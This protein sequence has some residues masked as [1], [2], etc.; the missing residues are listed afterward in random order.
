MSRFKIK[1]RK[2]K[3]FFGF[4]FLFLFFASLA[5]APAARAQTAKDSDFDGLTDQA[6]SE[7]YKTDPLQPDTDADGYLDGAEIILG[8]DPLDKNDPAAFFAGGQ[9]SGVNGEAGKKA[10][11]WPWYLS[12]SFGLA[13][14]LLMFLV[15][16]LGTGIT[17]GFLHRVISPVRAAVLHKYMSIALG[18]LV[19]IHIFSLA[20]DE[21]INFTLADILVPLFSDFK[22]LYLNMGI[23]S[24]YLLLIIV[25]TSLFLINRTPRLWRAIH[26]SAYIL[27]PLS[28]AHGFFIGT[29]TKIPAVRY[30]YYF[31]GAVFIVL[32][33]YR[34]YFFKR[35]SK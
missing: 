32:L 20:F 3:K 14:F 17:A 27:F 15:T 5:F 9:V 4:F 1:N 16:F 11:S 25:F 7:I 30:F 10:S 31:S 21:F 13:A 29:D 6:E 26:Y 22:P 2:T 8:S 24:F 33:I 19:L 28:L 18:V 34:F 12:R 23:V 35:A